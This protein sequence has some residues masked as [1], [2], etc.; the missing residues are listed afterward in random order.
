M[1]ARTL[2]PAACDELL[3]QTKSD[4][5]G[6]LFL[7]PREGVEGNTF[8][9]KVDIPQKC[10]LSKRRILSQVESIQKLPET[11]KITLP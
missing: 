8:S 3:Q 10:S 1:T 6:S 5:A 2:K 11:V 7:R 9:M 4:C